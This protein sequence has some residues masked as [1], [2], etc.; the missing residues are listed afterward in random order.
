MGI[1]TTNSNH[2]YTIA[3]NRVQQDFYATSPNE[4]YVGDITYIPTREG[5]LYLAT[6]IDLYSRKIVGWSMD[7]NITTTLVNDALFMALKTRNPKSGLMWHTDRG[8]QYAADSH[9]E[10]L[11]SYGIIQSMSRRGNCYD[12]AVAESF[13]H[14]LKT[15]LTHHIKFETRSQANQ[16]IFEYIEVF[17][18]RQRLHSSNNYLSPVDFENQLLQNVKGA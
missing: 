13:F 17:Y 3:L 18:N 15:E 8:S 14:S 10:L 11:K 7:A 9:R 1:L 5:W 6:V 12:N 16:A 4:I 2:N